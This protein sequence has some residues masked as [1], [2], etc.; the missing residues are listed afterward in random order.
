MP[1]NKNAQLRYR[2]LDECF[3]NFQRQYEIE[4][5]LEAVNVKLYDFEGT[6]ISLR[7]LRED[8]KYMRDSVTYDAPIKAYPFDGKKCYYRYED[9]DFSIFKTSLSEGDINKLQSTIAMLSKYRG[10]PANEWLEEVI[11]SL[12]F[13][14][15]IKSGS[16]NVI[17]FEQIEKYKG[18][19][20]L[21]AIIDATIKH[22]PLKIKYKSYK[23]EEKITT[24]HP[25]LIKQYNNRWFLFGLEIN[26]KYGNRI[27]NK[28][29]DRIVSVSYVKGSNFIPNT[30]FNP[31]S[32]FKDIIGVTVPDD[33]Q[34]PEKIILKFDQARFPYIVSKPIHPS[35][36]VPDQPECTV[37]LTLRVNKEFESLIFS[38]IPQVEVVE[39]EWLRERILKKITDYLNKY[40]SVQNGCIDG[41]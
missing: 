2:V 23:G 10:L 24:V 27:T 25:Y 38:F 17:S 15:G 5:L 3:S 9:P 32:Y 37:E 36:V 31:N 26:K 40:S 16:E 19:K 39:P 22:I 7:Q 21:S 34:N 4:D 30:F 13:R 28:A 20:H 6:E 33:H 35:Q 12:E 8:I 11:S 14:F 41:M 1:T 18:L 29:L